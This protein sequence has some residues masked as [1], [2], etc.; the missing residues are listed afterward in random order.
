MPNR[1][2]L[3]CFHFSREIDGSILSI[4]G[5]LVEFF[6]PN[7]LDFNYKTEFMSETRTCTQIPQYGMVWY[8]VL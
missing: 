4:I 1:R 8:G 2:L 6:F 7:L 5:M 3:H